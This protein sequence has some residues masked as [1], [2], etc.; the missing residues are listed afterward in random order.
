M[1]VEIPNAAPPNSSISQPPGIS[2]GD[3]VITSP[4]KATSEAVKDAI[5]THIFN[6]I[7]NSPLAPKAVTGDITSLQNKTYGI[8]SEFTA[9]KLSQ[10]ESFLGLDKTLITTCITD[11]QHIVDGSGDMNHTSVLNFLSVVKNIYEK[12]KNV[13]QKGLDGD[14]MI[15]ACSTVINLVLILVIPN[16]SD[17]KVYLSLICNVINMV[18]M[19][20]P[21]P[22]CFNCCF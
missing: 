19:T 20:F 11:I 2:V 18:K 3:V 17:L 13:E 16:D 22:K 9:D 6:E 5:V 8:F 12:A 15:D 14:T 1:S 10:I 7:K 21:N 4:P